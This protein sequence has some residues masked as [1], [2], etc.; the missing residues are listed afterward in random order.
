MDVVTVDSHW[1]ILAEKKY[2]QDDYTV[3]LSAHMDTVA[4]HPPVPKWRNN[5]TEIYNMAGN[6]ALGGDDKCG[7]AAHLAVIREMNRGTQFTGT[8]KVCFS[9]EEEIGCVGAS[10]AVKLNPEWF[11]G[12][13]ACIV[14]DRKGSDNIVESCGSWERF[15]SPEYSE[16]WADMATKTGFMG[17]IQDGSISDTMIFSELGINGVNLSAGYYHAHTRDEYIRID[18]LKRTVRWILNGLDEIQSHQFPSFDYEMAMANKSWGGWTW[19]LKDDSTMI[20]CD[21]CLV[22]FPIEQMFDYH[23]HD[24]CYNCINDIKEGAI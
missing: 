22:Q 1:N 21:C 2:G 9:R 6:G 16:F 20:E 8:L 10:K 5:K 7:I 14:V 11:E 3:L 15:C 12:I 17:I 23:G 4:S 19:S 24:V 18:E 13:N